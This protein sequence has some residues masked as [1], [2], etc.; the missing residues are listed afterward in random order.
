VTSRVDDHTLAVGRA[1]MHPYYDKTRTIWD[2]P[3]AGDIL[4][5]SGGDEPLLAQ[6]QLLVAKAWQD[7]KQ[8]RTLIQFTEA[9]PAG[10][11]ENTVL[12]NLSTSPSVRI[13]RCFVH[14]NRARGMLLQTRDVVVEDCVFEDISGAGIQICTDAGD[15]FAGS[16]Y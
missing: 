14:G 6:G 4:E 10:I 9:L 1:R 15:W 16:S 11:G 8:Q 7:A 3:A 5:Y 12:S 13:R 2:A